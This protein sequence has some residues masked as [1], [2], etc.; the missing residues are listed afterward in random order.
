MPSAA[1]ARPT[2][3]AAGASHAGL[4]RENNEDR[5][6]CDAA[7]GLFM[8]IDGVGGHAAGEKAAETALTMIRARLE[9][10]TGQPADRVREAIA[11]ANNEIVRLATSE[12]S[13]EGMACVLTVA[14]VRDGRVT[15]GHVGDTRLYAFRDGVLAK[16]THDHSPVGEREDQGEIAEVEAMR[17]PRRN[18]IYRDVGSEHHEPADESFIELLEMPFEADT[19]L[20]LCT[21]GLS[22]MLPS[23]RLAGI[24]FEHAGSPAVIVERLIEAAN[25]AGGKDNV[26][27]IFVA[28]PA[29]ADVARRQARIA[30]QASTGVSNGRKP[31]GRRLRAALTSR[32]ATLAYGVAAGLT[33]AAG[34]VLLTGI[35]P[36]RVLRESRPPGW[37][38][39]WRVGPTLEADFATI[40]EALARAQRGDVVE[41]DPGTYDLPLVVPPDVSLVSRRSREAVL[42]TPEGGPV[43]SP[44]V[45]V[46]GHSRVAGFKIDAGAGSTA[47]L[48]GDGD[49]AVLED[50]EIVGASS[51]G[52]MF[53]PGSRATLRGSYLHDNPEVAVLVTPQAMPK[54]LHNV[55]TANGKTSRQGVRLPDATG[56]RVMPA[57]VLQEGA[58]AVFFGN[59]IAGNA[60]DAISGL[61]AEKKAD[62]LRDNVIGLPAPRT[63]VPTRPTVPATPRRR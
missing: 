6:H 59:V 42:H 27:T 29:F 19:A 44:G 9:R 58:A 11:L 54:L 3:S 45:R 20:L 21:D 46:A 22:D 60:D 53:G 32:W 56:S 17:H 41:V 7:R 34:A 23:S 2:L 26:T 13:W 39:T 55:I 5:F 18:E 51:Y 16:V 50:L 25:E 15:I 38:R 10:E 48:T 36:D 52:V 24:V 57:V 14:L 62:V 33:I 49:E 35:V 4:Q 37:A 43:Q 40:P 8:V 61:P 12:P 28:G 1:L 63:A 31:A 30:P 47:V